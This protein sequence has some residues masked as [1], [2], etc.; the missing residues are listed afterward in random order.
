MAASLTSRTLAR[1]AFE[2]AFEPPAFLKAMLAFEA[3]LADGEAAEGLIPTS[4]AAADRDGPA[5]PSPSMSRRS[6]PRAS[7]RARSSSRS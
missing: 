2:S 1:P 7:A 4:S 3:A 6:S 5:R